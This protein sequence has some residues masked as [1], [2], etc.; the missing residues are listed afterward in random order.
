LSKKAVAE[1]VEHH[2][3]NL[4]PSIHEDMRKFAFDERTSVSAQ[5]RLACERYIKWMKRRNG[6]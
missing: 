6:T 4:T 5:V 3:I 1:K 2:K